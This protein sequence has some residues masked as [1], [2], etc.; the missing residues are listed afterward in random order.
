MRTE[1]LHGGW[2]KS[3]YSNNGTDCVEVWRKS[4]YSDNGSDCVEVAGTL[5]RLRDSKNTAGPALRVD[6]DALLTEIKAGRF[7]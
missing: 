7:Q 5:D 2:R 4:S 1:R 3:S 6:L